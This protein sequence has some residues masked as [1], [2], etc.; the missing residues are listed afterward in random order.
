MSDIVTEDM[1]A[2]V[3]KTLMELYP[4]IVG[5]ISINIELEKPQSDTNMQRYM[6][7][8]NMAGHKSGGQAMKCSVECEREDCP[9]DESDISG[10]DNG[11]TMMCPVC[12]RRFVFEQRTLVD[13]E[14]DDYDY[15]KGFTI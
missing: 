10:M 8:M 7:L 11:C 14:G 9:L 12:R 6:E 15:L 5:P 13:T 1:I 2:P 4:D 3:T